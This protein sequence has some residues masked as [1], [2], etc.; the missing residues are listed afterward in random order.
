MFVGCSEISIKVIVEHVQ[1]VG[2]IWACSQPWA[3]LSRFLVPE[4][5]EKIAVLWFARDIST[6]ANTMLN[7]II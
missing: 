4:W 1:H 7:V 2:I 5:T 6:L 3:D